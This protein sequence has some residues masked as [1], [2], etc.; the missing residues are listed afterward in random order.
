MLSI[1]SFGCHDSLYSRR[2]ENNKLLN[3]SLAQITLRW[4]VK[5]V[6]KIHVHEFAN[7][8]QTIHGK[9]NVLIEIK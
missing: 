8:Q 3:R 4:F 5:S 9:G 6:V 2:N 7:S 1:R